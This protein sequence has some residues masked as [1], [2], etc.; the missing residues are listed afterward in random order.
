MTSVRFGVV[1][2]G[3]IGRTHVDTLLSDAVPEGTVAAVV[4][5]SPV[6][7]P[8]GV[9]RFDT[10]QELLASNLAD[11]VVVAT[12]TMTHTE[13]GAR[14]LA[15]DCH[16]VMEKPLAMSLK[17]A[18][19]LTAAVPHGRFA[20]VM[21][22]QRYHPV[23][24]EIKNLVTRGVLGRIVRFNW[25]MTSWYRPDV[26][27]HVSSWRGTWP[28][29]GGGALLNQC[30][31]NLDVLQ[32]ILGMPETVFA[33]VRFGKYHDIEVEDE[34]SALLAYED[35]TT[36]VVVTSTGEAPGI[37]R[38]DIVGD[39]GT[40]SYD[41][42]GL[43]L[44][45]SDVSVAQHCATTHDMFG[46]P[47]FSTRR[48]NVQAEVNQHACVFNDVVDA[49]LRD[50]APAT[51]LAEGLASIELANAILY[52]A[53]QGRRISLPLDAEAYESALEQRLENASLRK[54]KDVEVNIDMDASYR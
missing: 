10:T 52:S 32:W 30:I 23:Y 44:S 54:P 28:G 48:V 22:N 53:W 39:R 45:V 17:Q 35:G 49:I 26:Y 43:H 14:I 46:M 18:R 21:L 34:A 2:Y 20:A 51:P 16:L 27:F 8:A 37:N 4:S 1:G 50:R 12:P 7:L 38:L 25:L 9:R 11:A 36:G 3:N 40:L 41:E 33:D 6:E 42:S 29:E 15:A 19:H 5:R 13:I 31:H 47:D 24:R